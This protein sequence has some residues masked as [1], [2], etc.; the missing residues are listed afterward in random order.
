M[1]IILI[2]LLIRTIEAYWRVT[3]YRL[4]NATSQLRMVQR[5][6][7][8]PVNFR[9]R[10]ANYLHIAIV[11]LIIAPI[12]GHKTDVPSIE[13]SPLTKE[14]AQEEVEML[15][16]IVELLCKEHKYRDMDKPYEVTVACA[17]AKRQFN[18][19]CIPHSERIPILHDKNIQKFNE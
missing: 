1:A 3:S 5:I 8:N 7:P 2:R 4:P 11:C 16:A 10:N 15:R 12:L 18:C 6:T 19:S 9:R 14:K 17:L 13:F